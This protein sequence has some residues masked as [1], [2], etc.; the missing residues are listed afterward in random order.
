MP[1]PVSSC[2]PTPSPTPLDVQNADIVWDTGR[3]KGGKDDRNERVELQC[4]PQTGQ[5]SAVEHWQMK[6]VKN[7]P[8]KLPPVK[9]RRSTFLP[10]A[11]PPSEKMP[12]MKKR[13]ASPIDISQRRQCELLPGLIGCEE[14]SGSQNYSQ[15]PYMTSMPFV[16]EPEDVVG[17]YPA[18]PLHSDSVTTSGSRPSSHRYNLRPS[19][20]FSHP[21]YSAATPTRSSRHI[22]PERTRYA[23]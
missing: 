9:A 3:T 20:D 21:E 18:P 19:R 10:N 17:R 23:Y 1:Q 11:L 5:S 16:M 8:H 4:R 14:P 13:V 6:K 15:A 7:P 12:I 22:V 2:A